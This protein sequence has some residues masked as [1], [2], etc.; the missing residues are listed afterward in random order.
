[1][2]HNIRVKEPGSLQE[3]RRAAAAAGRRRPDTSDSSSA[4]SPAGMLTL[5]GIRG[6]GPRSA[7][8][9]SERFTSLGEIQEA[10]GRELAA[11]LKGPALQ[12]V[13]DRAAWRHAR[14]EA[15]RTLDAA[16]QL[17]VQVIAIA[18]D[19]Y[20]V[21]L[22]AIPDHPAVLFV[23]GAL[24]QG[25]RNVACVGTR[26]PSAAGLQV[27][28]KIVDAL[29]GAG[30]TIVSGL[31]IG[32][33]TEAHNTALDRDAFTV[34]ILPTSL[35]RIYPPENAG[36][37]DRILASGGALVSELR[38]GT[39]AS[40]RHFVQR[41][42]LQSGMSVAT[43]VMQTDLVGGSMHTVR[44]TLGQRR[45]LFAAVP[46]PAHAGEPQSR[47]IMALTRNTGSELATLIADD[48]RYAAF[49][50]NN[51]LSSPPAIPV[52][53]QAGYESLLER[54]DAAVTGPPHPAKP[55]AADQRRLF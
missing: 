35:D 11:V 5:L 36:L 20:P 42:R 15:A 9:L 8:R 16:E 13:R 37:A 26:E 29:A 50:R 18:D 46:H 21:L 28:R 12:A 39:G 23:K 33:D 38:F 30:W 32:V 17:G 43:V 14:S 54:L 51:F 2:V 45:L 44:F 3:H 6:I 10:P 49:L 34:A 48:R 7:V 25:Q 55:D 53:S 40:P 41:D 24:R 4:S 47:G 1:M 52:S 19:S 22:R 27:T 31:A